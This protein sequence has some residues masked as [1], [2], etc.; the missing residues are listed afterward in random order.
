MGKDPY[1]RV[2]RTAAGDCLARTRC[3][4][5]KTVDVAKLDH[6]DLRR[7]GH[8][9]AQLLSTFHW[10]G[11]SQLTPDVDKRCAAIAVSAMANKNLI[12][13]RSAEMAAYLAE[14]AVSYRDQVKP[15]L[16]NASMGGA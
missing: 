13:Q 11:L 5:R 8:L 9:Y 15:L 12:A 2:L 16:K 7:L 1:Q 14:L 6:G 10:Q 4:T 3:H